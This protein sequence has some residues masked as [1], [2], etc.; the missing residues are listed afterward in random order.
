MTRRV[1][2]ADGDA[3]GPERFAEADGV[4]LCYQS[5]GDPGDP[6]ADVGDVP[7]RAE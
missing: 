1:G 3:L 6:T 4:R 7:P 5:V 2:P